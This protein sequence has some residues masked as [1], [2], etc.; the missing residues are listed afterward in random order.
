MVILPHN[1]VTAMSGAAFG[2]RAARRSKPLHRSVITEAG[3]DIE[4]Y[5]FSGWFGFFTHRGKT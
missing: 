1:L 2:V 4:R 3:L 5:I